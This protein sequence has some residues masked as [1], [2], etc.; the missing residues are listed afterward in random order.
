MAVFRRSRP[1][2]WLATASVLALA[3]CSDGFDVDMR[4][5]SGGLDTTDAT[6]LATEPR[7]EPD[8]RGVI[9]YP[10]FQVAVA[11]RG[12][13]IASLAERLGVSSAELAEYNGIAATAPLRKGEVIALPRRVDA[14]A[15]NNV[16]ITSLASGALDRVDGGNRTNAAPVTTTTLAPVTPAAPDVATGSEPVRHKVE[17]GETAYSIARLYKVSVRSLADWNGLGPDMN[18]RQGQFL[19]I[20]VASA[21]QPKPDPTIGIE[22]SVPGAGTLTPEPPSASK[23][24]P[25]ETEIASAAPPPSPALSEDRSEASASRL[26]LPVK[27]SIIRPYAKGSNEGI[28]IAAPAGTKV[29]AAD[30]GTVAAITRDTEQVPILVIRHANNLLTVYAN[31]ENIPVA[32]GDRVTRGQVIAEL[33][34]SAPSFLHFEV[35]EGF[36]SV[37]PV[38]FVN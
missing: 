3:A 20:P 12:D 21:D 2:L 25:E 6:R 4:D 18:V 30:D 38:P 15:G 19:L 8:A 1:Q 23:P 24:L 14:A 36:D 17:R 5:L 37:D 10:N 7:P 33:R 27:G 9:T 34:D 26:L 29:K 22:T 28:D 31:I 35:R 16:D 11:Q 32:K 13:T